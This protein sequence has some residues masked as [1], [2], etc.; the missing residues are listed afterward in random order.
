VAAYVVAN[1]RVTN[2]ESYEAYPSAV[3]PILAAHGAEILVADLESEVSEGEAGPVTVVLKFP[4]MEAAR[5]F[6]D[7][8]EYREIIHLR[9]DN[10]E[11]FV[12]FTNEF[13]APG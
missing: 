8:P 9:T 10:T 3:G 6:Y 13:V 12:A 1:Y 5:A 2:P 7:S 4:T 11:G